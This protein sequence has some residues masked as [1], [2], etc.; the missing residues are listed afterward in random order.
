MGLVSNQPTY[1]IIHFP[2]KCSTAKLSYVISIIY[3]YICIYIY[4]L[5]NTL[6]QGPNLHYLHFNRLNV[7]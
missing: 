4:V 6:K 3:I 2:H 1:G 7:T 5:L